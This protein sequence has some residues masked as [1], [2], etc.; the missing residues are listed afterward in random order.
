LLRKEFDQLREA[1]VEDLYVAVG[2][3]HD[4]FGLDIAMYDSRG[5]SA[6]KRSRDLQRDV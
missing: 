5:V 3:Q 6:R 1:E 4:I 2:S